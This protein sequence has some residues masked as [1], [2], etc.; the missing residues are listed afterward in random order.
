MILENIKFEELDIKP[1]DQ[2]IFIY[3][4]IVPNFEKFFEFIEVDLVSDQFLEKI[5]NLNIYNDKNIFI[6][7][8]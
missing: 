3:K 8:G 6:M 2:K 1:F 4:D 7:E 5:N